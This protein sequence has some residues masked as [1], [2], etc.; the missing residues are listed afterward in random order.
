MNI[1]IEN[2]PLEI[3]SF[4]VNSMVIFVVI[5]HKFYQVIGLTSWIWLPYQAY[6]FLGH[7]WNMSMFDRNGI[8][9]NISILGHGYPSIFYIRTGNKWN[10]T[11]K[12]IDM[13]FDIVEMSH[14]ILDIFPIWKLIWKI[15]P[16]KQWG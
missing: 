5:F 11:P 12:G 4:P 3:V 8:Y 7:L 15:L 9:H 16:M 1:P 13:K 10:H 2:G 6:D 14:E